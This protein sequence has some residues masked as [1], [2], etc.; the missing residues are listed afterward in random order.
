MLICMLGNQPGLS[1]AELEAI[2]GSQLVRP[3]GND[4]A[5][6]DINKEKLDHSKLGG[7]I[8]VAELIRI[9]PTSRLNNLSSIA[10]YHFHILSN[11]SL[12]LPSICSQFRKKG[13]ELHFLC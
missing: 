12:R 5:L 2:A 7:T 9:I 1:V 10:L 3:L 6:V 8:K 13:Q 4:Y 11:V